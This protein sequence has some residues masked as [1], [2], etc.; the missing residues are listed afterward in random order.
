[1]WFVY[2]DYKS[3]NYLQFIPLN[4]VY[5]SATVI[6]PE[7]DDGT[8]DAITL[9]DSIGFPFGSSIQTAIYV[10]NSTVVLLCC[11]CVFII[12][13]WAPMDSFHLVMHTIP[14]STSSSHS[15]LATW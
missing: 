7:S 1:M 12:L 9:P 10:S 6:L 14:G 2:L 5:G 4:V 3:D 15:P 8:S 11:N 13:R